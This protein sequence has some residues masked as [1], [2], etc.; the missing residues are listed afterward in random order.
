MSSVTQKYVNFLESIRY[1][2]IPK[3]AIRH[4]KRSILDTIGV[5][6]AAS[7]DT[8]I[9]GI[10]RS[11]LSEVGGT[12]KST[13][14]RMGLKTSAPE[15]AF[16]NA[17][18]CHYMD[19]DDINWIYIG[20]FSTVVVPALL[21]IGETLGST[22]KDILTAYL[23]SHEITSKIGRA[24]VEKGDHYKKGWHSTGTLG[25]FSS[26]LAAAKLLNLDA[27]KTS[28]MLGL[29]AGQASGLKINFGTM[30][31][32]FQA[33]H[34]SRNGVVAAILSSKGMTGASEAIEQ[35]R[36]FCDIT[37]SSYDKASLDDELGV[38]WDILNPQKGVVF[39]LYPV[40]G[41]GIGIID[42]VIDLSKEFNIDPAEVKRVTCT[43]REDTAA[44][45]TRGTPKTPLEGKFSIPFWVATALIDHEVSPRQ[46]TDDKIK[47][48][49]VQDTM[50]KVNIQYSTGMK[51]EDGVNVDIELK[52]GKKYSRKTWPPRG[53][54]DN[55]PSDEDLTAKFRSCAKYG[56][57]GE[58]EIQMI[59]KLVSNIEELKDIREIT[60]IIS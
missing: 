52:N 29:A 4:S 48:P 38:H 8:E 20:H 43:V 36:G 16:C 18:V 28:N 32:P 51:R 13:V 46:F 47:D 6:I 35:T 30:A 55:P 1:E 53:A 41:G 2:K 39:K 26:A 14:I 12:P 17:I 15:A 33:G 27:E 50:S 58:K 44:S 23:A 49:H 3:E 24:I 10:L 37:S 9:R 31:K 59:I 21:A 60:R 45:L 56:G 11:Y 57:L 7:A 54:P 25:T 42:S 5:G 40:L 34:A 22:G 19:Y